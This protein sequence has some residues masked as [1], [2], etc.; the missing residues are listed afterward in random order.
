MNKILLPEPEISSGVYSGK[1]KE[2]KFDYAEN[3][4]DVLSNFNDTI[5]KQENWIFR[6]HWDSDSWGLVP[7][8]LRKEWQEKLLLE[9]FKWVTGTPTIRKPQDINNKKIDFG[10]K[11]K[12]YA[13]LK[14]Q[15]MIEHDLL[16]QFMDTANLLSI[17]CNHILSIYKHE[18]TI[19]KASLQNN[20]KELEKWPYANVLPLMSLAQHHGVPTRLLDFTYNPLLASFFA[21]SHP[22]FEE[23]VKKNKKD[24]KDKRLCVWAIRLETFHPKLFK[25]ITKPSRFSKNL[26]AQEGLLILDKEAS[27][28]FIKNDNKGWDWQNIGKPETFIKFSLPQKEYKELLYLLWN[29][30]MT[31]AKTKPNLDNVIQTMEY[32]QWLWAKKY[33]SKP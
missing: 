16:E 2:Y 14:Y 27:Q 26:L 15:I 30:D 32:I 33:K 9:P 23:Y 25:I 11:T 20:I 1:Y 3:F 13:Q 5:D 17:Q 12:D 8:V 31:P 4:Y 22:F 21:A 29:D 18:K 19:K 6:G 24:K 10:R 7:S 28:K